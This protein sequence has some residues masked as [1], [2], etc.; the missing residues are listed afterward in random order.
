MCGILGFSGQPREGQWG[1]THRLLQALFQASE[2]RGHHATGFVA[3][4]DP[5]K[6]HSSGDI[7]MDKRPLKASQ[8][9]RRSPVWRGLRRRRCSAVVGHVRWATH[10]TP[11]INVN[12]HPFRGRRNLY[13]VHNGVL[14]DYEGLCERRGLTLHTDCDSEAILRL[15]ETSR[16]PAFGLDEA[17]RDFR[18]SMAVVVYDGEADCTYLARNDGRPLWLM[19]LKHDRRWWYASTRDI[20]LEG[21]SKAMGKQAT[22]RVELLVPLAS[23]HV[24]AL[25]STGALKG[26]PEIAGRAW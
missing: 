12:N 5:Y 19:R 18:G 20:L 4:T 26:I 24:H 10:G 11:E 14:I 1:E 8:F 13:L 2:H 23:G 6:G 7:L 15:V 3:R 16:I 22:R 21:L 25:T 17:L 9:V